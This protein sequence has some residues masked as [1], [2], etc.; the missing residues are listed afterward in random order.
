[1]TKAASVLVAVLMTLVVMTLPQEEMLTVGVLRQ[2]SRLPLQWV[3]G[4]YL[5]LHHQP[6]SPM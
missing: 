1:M 6:A 4:T 2:Q 5:L 3:V